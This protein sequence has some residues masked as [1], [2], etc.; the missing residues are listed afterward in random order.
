MQLR[1]PLHDDNTNGGNQMRLEKKLR[2]SLAYARKESQNG[3]PEDIK[4]AYRG[5]QIAL[6]RQLA[7]QEYCQRIAYDSA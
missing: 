7:K 5:I 3:W 1:E 6:K 2:E 4:E